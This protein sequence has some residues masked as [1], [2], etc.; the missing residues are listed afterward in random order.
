MSQIPVADEICLLTSN[1]YDAGQRSLWHMDKIGLIVDCSKSKS[2]SLGP[3]LELM[4]AVPRA[5]SHPSSSDS[6]LGSMFGLVETASGENASLVRIVEHTRVK[7]LNPTS[8]M[9]FSLD[10]SPSMN[11]VDTSFKSLTTGCHLVD[12]LV[13]SLSRALHCLV[14]G[15]RITGAEWDYPLVPTLVATVVVHGV[16][17]LGVYPLVVGERVTEF[18]IPDII[19]RVQLGIARPINFLSH[20]LQANHVEEQRS[21]AVNCSRTRTACTSSVCQANDL[22]IV[23]R[24]CLTAISLT[25]AQLSLSKAMVN[26]SIMVLTDGVFAHPRKLPY[27][28]ILMHLNFVDVAMH[29]LQVGGGFAPWSALGYAS[30]PDMLRLLAAST[31]TGL[32]V[33]DHHLEHILDGAPQLQGKG[34]F[35]PTPNVCANVL[36]KAGSLKFSALAGRDQRASH[37]PYKSLTYQSS[38]LTAGAAGPAGSYIDHLQASGVSRQLHA[39]LL[40][41][42][43]EE[44]SVDYSQLNNFTVSSIQGSP[45][46]R[47]R[48]AS[49]D[50]SE[51][52]S[53]SIESIQSYLQPERTKARPYLYKQYVLPGV[54]SAQLIQLR[55]RE[56]FLKEK[57]S[58]QRTA[59]S[60][61]LSSGDSISFAIHWGPVME[62]VYEI[63]TDDP[64]QLI[65]IKLYLRMPSGDFFLKF[66]QQLAAPT[67]TYFGQMCRQID[68]F[69]E[70]IFQIDDG[71]ARLPGPSKVL[72]DVSK[73]HRWF[74]VRTLFVLLDVSVTGKRIRHG[75]FAPLIAASRESLVNDLKQLGDVLEDT[76]KLVFKLSGKFGEEFHAVQ[77]HV[78]N[79]VRRDPFVLMD[80][81]PDNGYAVAKL[82][83]GFFA[84]CPQMERDVVEHIGRRLSKNRLLHT[85]SP[86]LREMTSDRFLAKHPT[87]KK[88]RVPLVGMGTGE[89]FYTYNPEPNIV[90]RF[91]LHHNW[92]IACPPASVQ[93]DILSLIHDTRLK[94]GWKCIHET[95]GTVIYARLIHKAAEA[96]VPRFPAATNDCVSRLWIPTAKAKVET[97]VPETSK[98]RIVQIDWATLTE[99]LEPVPEPVPPPTYVRGVCTCLYVQHSQIR[100]E[101]PILKCQIWADRAHSEWSSSKDESFRQF[102]HSLITLE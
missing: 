21:G 19:R 6:L 93:S 24:D 8:V 9:V 91:M 85:P 53:D 86:I 89:S 47:R 61:T 68:A 90:N 18:S 41:G 94:D 38:L 87:A 35:G 78:T 79:T 59:S 46:V 71:L 14:T 101:K 13:D 62:I 63:G 12:N 92:E 54:C 50:T 28:N 37:M 42:I 76:G 57:P 65:R 84:M 29:I 88:I 82:S 27:D 58:I 60:Q 83:L 39:V 102:C 55:A 26:K 4:Y 97:P 23:V 5:V 40:Q 33:Q 25:C 81:S 10:L 32:F 7:F 11:V 99:A 56:G 95:S 70:S 2:V 36:W 69:V 72:T 75:M 3:D 74:T 66:K 73:W 22:T 43:D 100:G 52:E 45:Q 48:V 20:W 67:E 31:P 15:P 80:V 16:P 64:D 44:S 34:L 30:D 49:S 96:R 51:D 1:P 77:S 98:A 17:E